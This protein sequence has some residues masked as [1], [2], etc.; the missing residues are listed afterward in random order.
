[1]GEHCEVRFT[2]A[3]AKE[4]LGVAKKDA[5]RAAILRALLTQIEENG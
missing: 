3:A 4:M 1:M 2:N 5:K